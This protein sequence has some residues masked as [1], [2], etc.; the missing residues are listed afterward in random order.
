MIGLRLIAY[1]VMLCVC[2]QSHATDI[3]TEIGTYKKTTQRIK[4]VVTNLEID[5]TVYIFRSRSNGFHDKRHYNKGRDNVL[6]IPNAS[7]PDDITLVVWFH[8]LGGFSTKTFSRVFTQVKKI[9]GLN[10]SIAI[11]IPEMPWSINTSTRRTRQGQV[12]RY[13][14]EF[15]EYVKENVGRLST[16]SNVHHGKELGSVRLVVVGHSAGGSA[17]AAATKEGSMCGLQFRAIVWSDASY[18]HWL[19]NAWDNC[20]SEMDSKICVLVR[21]GDTPYTRAL[22]FMNTSKPSD[23]LRLRVLQRKE[24]THGQIGNNALTLANIFSP[25]C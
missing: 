18:D 9:V 2:T 7:G 14:D 12:W 23:N 13:N 10:H 1:A 3:S 15:S 20:L 5:S 8:G 19:H 4:K 6:L 25:G 17:I 21:K 16:W 11:S 24:W 22:G